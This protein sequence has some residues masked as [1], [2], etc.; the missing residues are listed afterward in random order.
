MRAYEFKDL[1]LIEKLKETHEKNNSL[2][3]NTVKLFQEKNNLNPED[4]I[5]HGSSGGSYMN[6]FVLPQVNDIDII[7]FKDIEVQKI[8]GIKM[9]VKII[10]DDD[11]NHWNI[12]IVEKDGYY[13]PSALD[14][15][16]GNAIKFLLNNKPNNKVYTRV[17]MKYLNISTDE[18][19]SILENELENIVLPIGDTKKMN[20]A[21][22]NIHLL[23]EAF[24]V[25]HPLPSYIEESL[26]KKERSG[27]IV[28]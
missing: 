8:E 11:R 13:F 27:K 5:I 28:K 16:K 19:M 15:L 2:I 10:S 22:A 23:K 18:L 6:Y 1:E 4:F 12:E 17:L 7:L 21:T 26:K 25:K 9:D 3:I 24:D 20:V 14:L